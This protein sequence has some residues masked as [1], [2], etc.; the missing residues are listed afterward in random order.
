MRQ[1]AVDIK[2]PSRHRRPRGFGHIVAPLFG[3]DPES[4]MDEHLV[5]MKSF[6]KAGNMPSD[7]TAACLRP[8]PWQSVQYLQ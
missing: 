3:A 6:I 5:R 8:C 7:A 4:Q 1:A 2:L